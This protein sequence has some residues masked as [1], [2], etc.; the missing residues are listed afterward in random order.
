[1]TYRNIYLILI[2]QALLS[3][4][5]NEEYYLNECHINSDP[6][7]SHSDV[8]NELVESL[9]HVIPDHKEKEGFD[10]ALDKENCRLV[11]FWVY[12]MTDTSNHAPFETANIDFV[13]KH[14]YHYYIA[15]PPNSY[16]NIAVLLNGKVE[17]FEKV[18]CENV[19]A[20]VEDVKLYVSQIIEDPN[21]REL[22]MGRIDNYRQ[23]GSYGNIDGIEVH[24]D[25]E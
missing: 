24:L 5:S 14:V 3:I 25:C 13:D 17:V 20:T 16:S 2:L 7:Y 15:Y 19:G 18:N 8:V 23:F 10:L 12:D 22:M 21:E 11:G 6:M 1:M 4:T 9:N